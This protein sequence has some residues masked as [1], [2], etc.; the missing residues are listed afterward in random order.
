[1]AII[2]R[3]ELLTDTYLYLPEE[4]DLAEAVLINII[5]NVVDYQIPEDDEVHYS[6]ALC[7][8]L[9]A[10]AQLNKAK[11]AVDIAANK[12]EK[13]GAVELERFEG[14]SRYAWD[15]YLKALPDICPYLPKG[16]YTPSKAIG[17]KIN[18]STPFVI[19]DCEV[20]LLA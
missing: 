17:M 4:S 9:K 13:V 12:R 10:A 1:M 16:G 19:D 8:T 7:K 15:D 20:D 3:A 6:E 11:G 14:A 18:P 2:D 5:D